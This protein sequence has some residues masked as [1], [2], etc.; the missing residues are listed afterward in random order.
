MSAPG[1]FATF[2]NVRARSAIRGE[3]DSFCSL[4]AQPVLTQRRHSRL[5]LIAKV[6]RIGRL[7]EG[8]NRKGNE[9][10]FDINA[11]CGLPALIIP[12]AEH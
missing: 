9:D 10:A 7:C 8:E 5:K 6:R 11:D 2:R 4:R 12:F 1:P 3:A